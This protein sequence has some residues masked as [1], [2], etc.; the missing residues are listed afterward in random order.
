V[1]VVV[2]GVV[3]VVTGAVV[4]VVSVGVAVCVSVTVGGGA[5]DSDVV[6][7][8]V[9]D[10]VVMVMVVD[11]SSVIRLIN[12][13]TISARMRAATAPNATSAAGVRYQGCSGGGTGAVG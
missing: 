11:E 13:Y 7:A 5:T 12:A 1:V 9:E 3:V 6:V 10:V 4:V 2:G 8:D